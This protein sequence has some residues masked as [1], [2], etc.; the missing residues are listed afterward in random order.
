MRKLLVQAAHGMMRSKKDCRLKEWADQL[1]ARRG[2]GKAAV[3]LA[4]KIAVLMHHL[5]VTGEVFQAYPDNA[6]KAA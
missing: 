4:R 3:G 5:W 1:K 2:K 6:K